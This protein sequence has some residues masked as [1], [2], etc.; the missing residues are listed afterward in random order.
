M[1]VF[2]ITDI[3]PINLKIGKTSGFLLKTTRFVS[4][5]TDFGQL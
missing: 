5:L 3:F 2:R 1:Y 4:I